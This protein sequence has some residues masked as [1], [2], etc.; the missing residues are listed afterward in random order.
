M[1][2]GSKPVSTAVPVGPLGR[3]V[4]PADSAVGEPHDHALGRLGGVDHA[5]TGDPVD[6][7]AGGGVDDLDRGSVV[8]LRVE[9]QP[10]SVV[11][12]PGDERGVGAGEHPVH[13]S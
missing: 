9:Q 13:Q 12:V 3:E 7:L 11:R 8:T 6:D 10:R 2:A 4:V 1:P 5:G